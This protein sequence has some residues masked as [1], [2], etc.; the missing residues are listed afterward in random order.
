MLLTPQR[1]AR[2]RSEAKVIHYTDHSLI[3][4]LFTGKESLQGCKFVTESRAR[5]RVRVTEFTGCFNCITD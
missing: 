3:C 1:G 2:A 5:A 4:S